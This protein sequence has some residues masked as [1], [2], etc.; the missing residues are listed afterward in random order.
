MQS[1]THWG[2]SVFRLASASRVV[3][4]SG[5]IKETYKS[6][7][8]TT[9]PVTNPVAAAVKADVAPRPVRHYR[10]WVF[11]GYAVAALIA[12]ATLF[13]LAYTTNY[14]ALDLQ[15]AVAIQWL[16]SPLFTAVMVAVSWPSYAPQT[17][18]IT[19]VIVVLIFAIGLRWEAVVALISSVGSAGLVTLIKIIAARPRP[20]ADLV[21][22]YQQVQD[23]SFPSGHVVFYTAFF[24]FLLFVVYTVF[25]QGLGRLLLGAVLAF[26]VLTIGLSRVYLG[27]HW[28]SDV[29]G[30]SVPMRNLRWN[31]SSNRPR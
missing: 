3:I 10:A 4:E 30:A 22:I 13:A 11:Q 28:P 20:A 25:R 26:L 1:S 29:L 8:S 14:F 23:Y 6:S 31:T 19:A 9:K 15:L 12:F 16:T 17:F 7:P 2:G 18:I 27:A 21:H 24:G 5:G